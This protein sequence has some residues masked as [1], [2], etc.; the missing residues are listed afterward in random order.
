MDLWADAA[1]GGGEAPVGEIIMAPDFIRERCE[2]EGW[3][4]DDEF[5]MLTIHGLLHVLGWDHLE[6]EPARLMR[7]LER[8]LLATCGRS[9]PLD[10]E[11]GD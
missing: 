8:E 9:H 3:P 4:L 10:A 7:A 11:K 5:A 1:P 2:R 6:P